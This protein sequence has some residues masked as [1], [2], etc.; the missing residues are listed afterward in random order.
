MGCCK[1]VLY[2]FL[3]LCTIPVHAQLLP[4][5]NTTVHYRIVGFK[6]KPQRPRVKSYILEVANGN[7]SA[8]PLFDD[9]IIFKKT[10]NKK[11][12][13]AEVPNWGTTYSWRINELYEDGILL[14]GEIWQFTT[15][16]FPGIDSNSMRMRIIKDNE[17]YKNAYFILD[18]RRGIFDAKGQLIWYLPAIEGIVNEPMS[19]FRDMK[20]T[21][22]S[23][24]T[25]LNTEDAIELTYQGKLLWRGPTTDPV[26]GPK[27]SK[28]HHEFTKINKNKYLLMTG[29]NCYFRKTGEEANPIIKTVSE[30]EF[31]QNQNVLGYFQVQFSGLEMIDSNG[32]ITWQWNAIDHFDIQKL[33]KRKAPYV[34]ANLDMHGNSFHFDEKN[35]C[36]YV[37][38]KTMN[39]IVK[40][41][42]P[43]GKVMAT[44]DG[45]S[46][47]KIKKNLF[48]HQHC[49]RINSLQELMVLNNNACDSLHMPSVVMMKP[50]GGNSGAFKQVW[51][52]TLP[53]ACPDSLSLKVKDKSHF[54]SIREL[55]DHNYFVSICGPFSDL[56]IINRKKEIL[57]HAIVEKRNVATNSWESASTY[58]A[59]IIWD[60][61]ALEA[62]I[63]K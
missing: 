46:D 1:L 8:G 57:W 26:G 44:Y 24:F 19:V 22:D 4:Y 31:Q 3:F 21:Q 27:K 55:P 58:R 47:K 33:Y 11:E 25:F 56:Y 62:L 36:I 45:S 48:C 32:N 28:Y 50:V 6:D 38:F 2:I 37:S 18:S 7:V 34:N 39:Q 42:Y 17:K 61:K 43:D 29:K 53:T 35:Q 41:H 20:E 30:S 63:W 5:Q 49:C 23:T 10:S 12:I 51:E 9:N 15:G 60:K 52:M 40:V 54:G 59:N 14:Y 16:I 13:I